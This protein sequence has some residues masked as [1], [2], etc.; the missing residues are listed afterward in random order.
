[1]ITIPWYGRRRHHPSAPGFG[2]PRPGLIYALKTIHNTKTSVK[3][4][5]I[6]IEGLLITLF[7]IPANPPFHI[8]DSPDAKAIITA[9]EA[10]SAVPDSSI[11]NFLM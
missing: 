7:H 9:D 2:R 8:P 4:T 5:K 11:K 3:T 10:A 1:L 6:N